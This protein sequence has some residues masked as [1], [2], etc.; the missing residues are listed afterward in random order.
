MKKG[1]LV[2]AA[3]LAIAGLASCTNE[4][5]PENQ[6]VNPAKGEE[7]YASFN[8]S[9][10]GKGTRATDPGLVEEQAIS[11]VEVYV[12]AGGILEAHQLTEVTNGNRTI[13]VKIS[14]G[15]KVVYVIAAPEAEDQQLALKK[16]GVNWTVTDNE[17]KLVDF[18]KDVFDAL[19]SDIAQSEHFVMIGRSEYAIVKCTY[20]E[21]ENGTKNK[22]GVT[23]DRASAKVLVRYDA[24]SVNIHPSLNADVENAV[25]AVCQPAKQMVLTEYSFL[26]NRN[27]GVFTPGG[28]TK[29]NGG[30]ADTKGTLSGYVSMPDTF[31]EGFFKNAVSNWTAAASI[32]DFEYCAESRNAQPVTGNTTFA[33]IRVDLTPN[34]VYSRA[35]KNAQTGKVDLTKANYSKGSD[36]YTVCKQDAKT[37][38]LVHASDLDYKI[39]YFTSDAAAKQYITAKG[40]T[41][42]WKSYKF[43]KGQV[44]YRVNIKTT[45][46]EDISEK[47]RVERNNYYQIDVTEIKALGAKNGDD[48]IPTDPDTPVDP[49]AWIST[50]I[51]VKDWTV[52]EMGNT[53]LQ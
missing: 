23:V 1:T 31:D 50:E 48:V 3:A 45:E 16:V 10:N 17:T 29:A 7:T 21:C 33:L 32:D 41:N 30:N 2:A 15:E 9:V 39:L 34:A 8:I 46:S 18:E 28:E 52:I 40:L 37:G 24:E 47:Y 19:K 27:G 14:T 53:V 35:A 6:G 5:N 44:Y 22:V 20:A 51:T 42:E 38:T 11:H 13:P 43:D 12:F 36:F 4:N 26:Q 49:E 25:F